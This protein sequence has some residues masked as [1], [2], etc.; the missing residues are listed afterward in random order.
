MSF[1]KQL[2]P[3]PTLLFKKL[4]PI[5]VSA[6]IHFLASLISESYYSQRMAMLLMDDT[7]WAKKQLATSLDS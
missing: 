5:L 7:L 6:E 1:L 3:K 4:A 2:P